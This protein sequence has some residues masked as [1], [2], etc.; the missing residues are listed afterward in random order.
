MLGEAWPLEWPEEH[1]RVQAL[2]QYGNSWIN[3]R[4]AWMHHCSLA[5]TNVFNFRPQENSIPSLCSPKGMMPPGY[6]WPHMEQGKYVRPEYL[7]E[8]QRLYE[9]IAQCAPNLVVAMGA[10]ACWALLRTTAIG[11]IRGTTTVVGTGVLAGVKVLPIYHPASVLYRWSQ[12]P[13]VVADLMKAHREG[14]YPEVR[15]PQRRIVVNPNLQQVIDWIEEALKMKPPL[16]ACDT[17]TSLNMIDTIGFAYSRDEA[18]VCQVGPHRVKRGQSYYTVWPQRDGERRV[19]YWS[20]EEEHVFWLTV[21]RLLESPIP[22]LFQNG[23]YDLQYLLR[24]GLRPQNVREDSMLLHHALFPEL[25]K[26]L[27][28]LGSIYTDEPAWK[29]MRRGAGDSVKRDE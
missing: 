16:L 6:D 11:S 22:K 13:I 12:R 24:M 2:H 26:G 7:P 10:T 20:P 29:L 19:S 8:V 17:E 5:F 28:F 15:R 27:G 25:P 1:Q 9:E 18:F 3:Q 4:S 23:V 14:Q 21:R